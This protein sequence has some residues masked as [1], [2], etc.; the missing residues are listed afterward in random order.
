M[1][2]EVDGPFPGYRV[3]ALFPVIVRHL[4]GW[5]VFNPVSSQSL[6]YDH[7]WV[8]SASGQV[9]KQWMLGS[10]SVSFPQRRAHDAAHLL[11]VLGS[12]EVGLLPVQALAINNGRCHRGFPFSG[13]RYSSDSASGG[14]EILEF[15]VQKGVGVSLPVV[16]DAQVYD[17]ADRGLAGAVVPGPSIRDG[18]PVN[19]LLAIVENHVVL[20]KGILDLL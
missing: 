12:Q 8:Q 7:L 10:V 11:E 2:H 19:L 6:H 14:S 16:P 1:D 5:A 18:W 3:C 15:G 17:L 4:E 9:Q 13:D 20:L